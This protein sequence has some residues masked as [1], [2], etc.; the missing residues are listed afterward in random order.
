MTAPIYYLVG[1]SDSFQTALTPLGGAAHS[2]AFRVASVQGVS[3]YQPYLDGENINPRTGR[4]DPTTGQTD[5]GEVTLTILD[6]RTT[7]GGSNLSRWVTAFGA[8]KTKKFRLSIS[9]DGGTTIRAVFSGRAVRAE[10][11]DD[12]LAFH[13][14]LRDLS[15]DLVSTP[16]FVGQPHRSA[17]GTSRPF[18]VP[19]GLAANY[20]AYTAADPL[21]AV[22]NGTPGATMTLTVTPGQDN[23]DNLNYV[24][25]FL[26]NRLGA[27]DDDLGW[28]VDGAQLDFFRAVVNGTFHF[29][30]IAIGGFQGA[31]LKAGDNLQTVIVAPLKDLNGDLATNDP[32]YVDLS[33]FSDTDPATV[34][35]IPRREPVGEEAALV[36]SDVK[37]PQ[38]VSDLLAGYHSYL[39]AAGDPLYTFEEKE[40]TPAAVS[41]ALAGAGAGNV[42]NG[43]H[44]Y[45]VTFVTADGET[46]PSTNVN[47]TVVDKTANGKVTVSG[48]PTGSELVTARKLYRTLAGAGTWKLLAT[49]PDNTTTTYLDNIADGSLTTNA[50][51]ANTATPFT[52][53]LAE[54]DVPYVRDVIRQRE[55]SAFEYLKA[56]CREDGYGW[57]I[58]PLGRF[59][60]FRADLPS[61]ISI[62]PLVTDDDVYSE[63][64]P[65]WIDEALDSITS[66]DARWYLDRQRPLIEFVNIGVNTSDKSVPIPS[67]RLQSYPQDIIDPFLAPAGTK[68]NPITLDCR[69]VRATKGEDGTNGLSRV[70]WARRR[71][72]TRMQAIRSLDHGSQ[73][74]RLVAKRTA[75]VTA[76]GV[77]SWV[78][79]AVS[80]LPDP[81][82]GLR[83]G[84]R[85]M[86]VTGLDDIGDAILLYLK[87]SGYSQDTDPPTI[88]TPT[89][90]GDNGYNAIDVD[91]DLNAAGEPVQLQI[92]VTA[93]S[94]MSA[95]ASDSPLWTY[96]KRVTDSDT[97]VLENIPSGTRVWIR[98]R[99]EPDFT[100]RLA[101]VSAWE[102]AGDYVDMDELA[103]PTSLALTAGSTYLAAAW[104]NTLTD[105]KIEVL[106][107]DVRYAILP[108]GTAGVNVTGLVV[109]TE[110]DV[111]VRYLD[112]FG[113]VGASDTDT[114]TTGT[115]AVLAAPTDLSIVLYHPRAKSGTL[116]SEYQLYVRAEQPA[117]YEVQWQRA[118]ETAPGS[119]VYTT[120]H[121]DGSEGPA[122][123]PCVTG[124]WTTSIPDPTPTFA[125]VGG[126][127]VWFPGGASEIYLIKF[128]ARV[129]SRATDGTILEAG[130]WTSDLVVDPDVPVGVPTTPLDWLGGAGT[131]DGPVYSASGAFASEPQTA[132][133]RG[134][135]NADL[136]ATGPG[137][138]MQATTGAALSVGFTLPAGT[139]EYTA[140]SVLRPV[141]DNDAGN[142]IGDPTHRWYGGYFGTELVVG[143]D[144][145]G[146]DSLRVTGGIDVLG[147]HY[148]LTR[149]A[150][151]PDFTQRRAQGN[152]SSPAALGSGQTIGQDQF[153][154]YDGVVPGT[155]TT[156]AGLQAVTT[157]GWDGTHHQVRFTYTLWR[158]SSAARVNVGS[159]FPS[160]NWRLGVATSDPDYAVGSMLA[161]G[162]MSSQGMISATTPTADVTLPANSSMV[163]AGPYTITSGINVTIPSTSTLLILA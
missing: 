123:S 8:V 109:E 25:Q 34:A 26:I 95:P 78:R 135:S 38:L 131:A 28:N 69:F 120:Y 54:A 45:K 84:T 115:A 98:G 30:I 110:Y 46:D 143:D 62:L 49:I 111:A 122:F 39:D 3:G 67:G 21:D 13:L 138:V 100:V 106:L 80:E 7:E 152:A 94:E 125:E 60:L 70:E 44:G 64:T 92:A 93:T 22:V 90:N 139:Y 88:G 61:D 83:G 99:S 32:N 147:N 144:P 121:D 104:T 31:E 145:G 65:T 117:P 16:V 161:E 112:A 127:W 51:S 11:S 158:N 73:T 153:S 79:V 55:P 24:S 96:A 9:T 47:V 27:V 75:I 81:D 48:I 146:S 116:A 162:Q 15:A 29:R 141:A 128:R 159:I 97:I 43:V 85:L 12:A 82:T 119:G 142:T 23:G 41:V 35:I 137:V 149:Y 126:K 14:T 57:R 50:P 102:P 56:L 63:V 17:T 86:R 136:S 89:V 6:K 133:S 163:V 1:Y 130:S 74:A 76:L 4:F 33:G 140:D 37:L 151:A 118:E 2:D 53:L 134:G 59:I 103:A 68:A 150:A 36:I 19:V 42:E 124:Y 107:D 105:Y 66:I 157:E 10:L 108:A 154:G 18:M 129:V 114:E 91:V 148:R 101:A 113:G 72:Q 156:V 77:G 58:S 71:A 52:A 132:L 20:G 87:D 40:P 5:V 160:G 155:F